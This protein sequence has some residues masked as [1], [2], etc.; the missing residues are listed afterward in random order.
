M[1][2]F[3]AGVLSEEECDGAMSL[4]ETMS[5]IYDHIGLQTYFDKLPDGHKLAGE[6]ICHGHPQNLAVVYAMLT[7]GLNPNTIQI[8]REMKLP[9]LGALL[10]D[11]HIL[12]KPQGRPGNR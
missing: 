11:F 2:D 8:T 12:E 1:L 10:P 3:R 6:K 4:I 9:F 7:I 5:E